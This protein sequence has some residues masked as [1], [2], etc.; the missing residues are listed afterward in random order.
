VQPE[1][2]APASQQAAA[3]PIRTESERAAPV[4]PVVDANA[5]RMPKVSPYVLPTDVLS[6]VAK[7]SGL[8]WVNSDGDKVAAVQAAIAAEPKPIHV[9][10]E[11]PAPV[12]IDTGPLILVETRRDLRNMTLPFEQPPAA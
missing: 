5:S 2:S 3:E 4:A 1:P 8:Q 11:R 7:G 10:R 6:E 12:A 9:P